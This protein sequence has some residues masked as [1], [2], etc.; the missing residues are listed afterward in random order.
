MITIDGNTA[1]VTVAYKLSEVIAIYPITPSSP[2]GDLADNWSVNLRT[3][4]WG[5]VPQVIEMQSEAGAAG[6]VHGALQR[7]ALATTFTSSQGLLLMIPNMYK[8]AGELLPT[9]F[10]VAARTIATHALSIFGDHSDVMACRSTGFAMLCAGSV[11]EAQDFALLSHAVTLESRVPVLH[12]FDGFRTSHEVAKITP[13]DDEQMRA[14]VSDEWLHEHRARGLSPDRPVM[15]GTTQNPDVYFQSREA[16]N[17][18]YARMP[19]AFSRAMERLADITGRRYRLFDYVGA[20]D[21]EHVLVIMGSGAEAAHDT[22]EELLATGARVGLLKVRLFRPFSAESLI[23]ALPASVT[24]IAVLDRT[25]EPGAAGE[26]LYQDVI[27]AFAEHLTGG[28][29]RFSSM[30][31]IIGGRYGLSSKEFTPGMIKAVYD[32][33]A[34]EQPKNHFTVGIH[35]DVSHTSLEW[36][37]QFE[38]AT[39]RQQHAAVFYGLGSDGT[40]SANRNTIQI[41]GE[42]TDYHAQG[43]FVFDSRKSGAVTVSHLRFSRDPIRSTYAIGE[44]QAGFVACHQTSFLE[45]YELLDIAKPNAIFLLNAPWEPEQV[46]DRLPQHIQAYILSKKLRVF[47]ID[48]YRV[49]RQCGL[50]RRINTVMQTCYFALSDLLPQEEAIERI[51]IAVSGSY[52]YKGGKVLEGNFAA[53]DQTLANLKPVPVPGVLTATTGKRQHIAADAAPFLREITSKLMAGQGDSIPVS[54]M[55]V[56]GTWPLGTGAYEKRRLALEVPVLEP[57]ICIQCGKCAF[58]CP[59][60]AIRSKVFDPALLKNAPEGFRSAPVVGNEF[61]KGTAITYQVSPEDC[62]GCTLCV[63]VCPG[64]DKTNRSRKALN[65]HPVGPIFE[66]ERAKWEFFQALPEYDRH[67]IRWNTIKGAAIGKPLFE[68]SSACVGCG[69]TTYIRLATQLFGDRMIIANATGCSSIY[70]G[71]LPTAPFTTDPNGRGPAWCNSLFEDNAEFG[72]GIRV[73]LDEQI[74]HAHQLLTELA[75]EVGPELVA[76]IINAEQHNETHI[77]Q[78]RERVAQLKARI[79]T[80]DS[81]RA[82]NLLSIID[83][84]VRKTVWII[85]GDGWAYDIGFAGLDHVLTS[86]R[87]VNILVLDTEVYSN[88][89]GQ[90]SKATPRAAVAK[91]AAGG[92]NVPKKDLAMFAMAYENVYVA[93]VASGAKDVQTLR[94]FQEAESWDGPSLIIAYSPCI[95]HGV[96]LQRNLTQQELAVKSGHWMLMRYDPRRRAAGENPLILDSNK[97][98]IPYREFTQTEMRFG[99]LARTQPEVAETL[100]KQAQEE[101]EKRYRLYE[102]VASLDF[103]GGVGAVDTTVPAGPSPGQTH[104]PGGQ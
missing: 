72:L 48:A 73:A 28:G 101:V 36:E 94:A 83:A 103:S 75:P 67:K 23:A 60:S 78:Q 84:L 74:G 9:V 31:R 11:Q 99:I 1:C 65:L 52:H 50:G 68:F 24:R 7:G 64:R 70:G 56:D 32:N 33:L 87:N 81:P 59:H 35:D 3:N 13:L 45:N 86:G 41:I 71:N 96:D 102:Q 40:I 20:A 15:R 82:R 39:D 79:E 6:A 51:K 95:A 43:H 55:P 97:P 53:I 26:P 44:N 4:S 54:G 62:T 90:M 17:P 42:Q 77:A 63:E 38:V 34:A 19:E 8:V 100:L 66:R 47:V 12:F 10:H 14:M 88:T 93:R 18:F 61:V 85:G 92:K 80:L 5:A 46:W 104:N 25:K 22:M 91:F 30:P 21:A 69:E 76:A 29:Q 58:V 57:D 49:A 16:V 37:S 98:Q 2:M 89:G 27:T